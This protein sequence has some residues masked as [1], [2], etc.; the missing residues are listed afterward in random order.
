MFQLLRSVEGE[1]WYLPSAYAEAPPKD[2][3]SLM[4]VAPPPTPAGYALAIPTR[5]TFGVAIEQ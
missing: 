2:P 1:G 3:E 4:K 5:S